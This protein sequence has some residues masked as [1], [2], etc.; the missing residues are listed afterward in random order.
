MVPILSAL[1][2]GALAIQ[3][4]P[5]EKLP[6]SVL[7]AGNAATPYSSVWEKF[8][9]AHTERV[10]FVAGRDLK[11]EDL[12]GYDVLVIDGEV[13]SRAPGEE[14]TLK[15]EKVKLVFDEMQGF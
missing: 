10:K 8:L 11:R 14:L 12:A 9:G 13:T 6:Y 3:Q 1:V 5:S 7:Y 4:S 2:L 15:S